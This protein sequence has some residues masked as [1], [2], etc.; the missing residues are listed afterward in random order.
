MSRRRA[1]SSGGAAVLGVRII[2]A[3]ILERPSEHLLVKTFYRG[4]RLR[5]LRWKLNVVDTVIS[6]ISA[7]RFGV[8]RD[9]TQ[10]LPP[11]H[12]ARS[13]SQRMGHYIVAALRTQTPV[14]CNPPAA[15]RANYPNLTTAKRGGGYYKIE[16]HLIKMKNNKPA[17]TTAPTTLSKIVQLFQP[18]FRQ[19]RPRN[20]R[21]A[22]HNIRTPANSAV[23]P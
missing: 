15:G 23:T 4:K 3:P 7:H 22:P 18:R 5:G 2:V 9:Q 16:I 20:S 8:A 14:G 21:K 6:W 12:G 17:P 19:A 1:D 10:R 13:A 11:N